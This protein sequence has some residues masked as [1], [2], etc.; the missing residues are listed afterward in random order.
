MDAVSLAFYATVCG[1]LGLAGPWL[2][3]AVVRLAIGAVVGLIA[4]AALP[5]LRVMMGLADSYTTVMP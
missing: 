4:V 1:L 2:G 3:R 5:A